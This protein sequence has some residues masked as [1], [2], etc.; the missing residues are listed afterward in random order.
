LSLHRD[1]T[2]WEVRVDD[3]GPG[4][5]PEHREAVLEPFYSTRP[6]GEG[7][8]LGL[9]VVSSVLKEHGGRIE[10]GTNESG[11]CKMS[12]FWPVETSA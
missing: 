1:A 10:I 8:G 2:E 3:D 11:G 6:A 7:T 5:V 9:A 4:I 12:L